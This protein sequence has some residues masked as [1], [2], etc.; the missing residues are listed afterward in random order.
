MKV[1]FL[2]MGLLFTC[3]FHGQMGKLFLDIIYNIEKTK[4]AELKI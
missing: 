3:S 4:D 2:S 1:F